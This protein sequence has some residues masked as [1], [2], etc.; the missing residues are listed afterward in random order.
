MAL[1]GEAPAAIV[2]A[3][4]LAPLFLRASKMGVEQ[5]PEFLVAPHVP[6]YRL[7]AD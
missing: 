5:A 2:V 7:V 6:I 4:A 1:A 3:I